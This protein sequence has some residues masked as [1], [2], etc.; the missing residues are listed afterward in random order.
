MEILA[1]PVQVPPQ[2]GSFDHEVVQVLGYPGGELR[3]L[4]DALDPVAYDGLDQG[5][6]VLVS[7]DVADLAL[8]LA[9]SGEVDDECFDLVWLVDHPVGGPLGDG[10]RG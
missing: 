5:D 3:L 8:A 4:E 1:V 2:I 7:E 6:P 9:F 10:S